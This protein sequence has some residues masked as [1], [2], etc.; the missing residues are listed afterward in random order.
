MVFGSRLTPI[1][2]AKNH[3]KCIKNRIEKLTDFFVDFGSSF[4]ALLVAK[5]LPKSIKMRSKRDPRHVRPPGPPQDA[6]IDRKCYKTS[7]KTGNI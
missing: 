7:A 5:K 4:S 2:A 3:T 6:H 1:W